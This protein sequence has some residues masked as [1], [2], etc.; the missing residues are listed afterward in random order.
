MIPTSDTQPT[1]RAYL[2]TAPNAADTPQLA[3][4]HVAY[5]LLRAELNS[6]AETARLLVS[7][8][9]SNVYVH[10]AVPSLSVRTIIRPGRAMVAV[11]DCATHG[12]QDIR[13]TVTPSEA[14]GGRGLRLVESLAAAWGITVHGGLKP[15]GKTVWFELR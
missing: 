13:P 6:L 14:V 9:V 4:D 2:L 8:V 7:E 3:R 12:I 15:S 11:R 1:V 10:T 5:L